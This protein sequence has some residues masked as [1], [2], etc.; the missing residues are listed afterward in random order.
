MPMISEATPVAFADP[1]PGAA[2][3]VVIGGGIAGVS[4]ALFLAERGV[5][6]LLVEKGR[7]A[8]EQS[9]RNWGW[10]RQQG[11]DRAELPLMMEANRIWRG[12]AERTGEPDLAY[13]E[14]GCLYLADAPATRLE[15]ERPR[16]PRGSPPRRGA[17]RAPAP[18]PPRRARPGR[19]RG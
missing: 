8:G 16:S 19:P 2:D 18:A 6:V 1:L 9:S 13:T 5:S 7:I 10:V 15:V 3:V 14:S 4:T 12:L 17:P 11:R